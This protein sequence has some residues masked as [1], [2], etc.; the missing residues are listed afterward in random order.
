MFI[1]KGQLFSVCRDKITIRLKDYLSKP[2]YAD[3]TCEGGLYD[4]MGF[5]DCIVE[6]KFSKLINA[7]L[8]QNRSV[9]T[10]DGIV[11]IKIS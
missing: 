11:E 10:A 4:L 2:K 9:I 3:I 1:V 7:R 5:V 8:S 6:V